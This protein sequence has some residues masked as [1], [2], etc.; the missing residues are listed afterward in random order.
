MDLGLAG[1]VA[2]VTGGS[3]GMGG[4]IAAALAEEGARVAITSRSR[5]RAEAAAKEIGAMP[6]AYDSDDLDGVPGVVAEVEDG[7]GP[8]DVLVVNTGGP[9]P[10]GDPFGFETSD[11]EAA[12]RSLVLAPLG[13]ARAVVPGMRERGFGRVLNV[14]STAVVEPRTLLLLSAAHRTGAVALFKVLATESAADGVTLNT[15]LPG[16]IATD[17]LYTMAGSREAA[18][19]HMAAEVPAQRL[20]TVEE[21]AAVGAFLCSA[22]ASYIT[23]QTVAVD[24]GLLR[25]L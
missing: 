5:E 2:L 17:R 1:R 25:S 20:G 7:L 13:L 4:G 24:G 16:R 8:I 11:W 18:H 9:P 23:G 21:I 10:G 12:H 6:V 15:L 14:A 3:Q 19:E 22:P